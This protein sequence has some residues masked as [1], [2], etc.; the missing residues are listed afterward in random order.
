MIGLNAVGTFGQTAFYLVEVPDLYPA[1][2]SA[3]TLCTD[4]PLMA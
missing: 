3:G 2:S 1:S 4:E